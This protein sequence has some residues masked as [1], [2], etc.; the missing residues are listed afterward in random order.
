KRIDET[1]KRIDELRV[2]L[3]AEINANTA[4]ID[5]TNKRIDSLYLEISEV[6]GDLKKAL[7]YKEIMHDFI[8]RLERLE[9]KVFAQ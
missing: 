8:L 9:T 6:R 2:E 4:R 1:N 5:E 3:K 7:S